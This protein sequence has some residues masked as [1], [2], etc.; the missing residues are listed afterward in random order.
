MWQ[1]LSPVQ[2]DWGLLL[3]LLGPALVVGGV[4]LRGFRPGALVRA[5]IWRYRGANALFVALVAVS[6]GMGIGILAQERGLRHGT[7]AAADKFDL[8]IGAPGSDITLMMA[9]VFLQPSTVPLI[10]GE[11]YHAIETHP[12]ATLTAPLA[13]GD[14][15]RGAPVVGTTA[16]FVAYLSGGKIE[17]KTFETSLQAVIGAEAPLDIGDVFDPDHGRT[18]QEVAGFKDA[19]AGVGLQVVGRMPPTG[20]PW[21]KAI[22][23]AV[24]SVWEVHGLANGHAPEAAD[25]IGPPFDA[26]FFPGTPAAI[27]HT[28]QLYAAYALQA[29]FNQGPETMA[30]FPGAVLSRLYRVLGDVRQVLSVMA[31]AT[32]V[33]VALSVLVGLAVLMRLF[34]RQMALLHALGAPRRFVFAVI[35]SYAAALLAT[36]AC[37]GLVVGQAATWGL[38]RVISAQTDIAISAPLGWPEFHAVTGFVA[39]ATVLALLPAMMASRVSGPAAL[40]G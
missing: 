22:L 12:L 35:W 28:D 5:L 25:R 26:P 1:A 33:L 36:G 2:Q 3:A 6:V 21:D 27:V 7:A 23:V 29:E 15:Y 34:G 19:H 16:E 10:G 30:F 37:G 8:I 32:Q 13:F 38:S 9:S 11:V 18:P 20:T 40:R 39:A 4:V 17:G 24:E 14:S 31:I